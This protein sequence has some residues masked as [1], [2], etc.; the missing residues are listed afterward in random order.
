MLVLD[1]GQVASAINV[2]PDISFG[3][4]LEGNCTQSLRFALD[5]AVLDSAWFVTL[6][7][8]ESWLFFGGGLS[9]S[10]EQCDQ[11]GCFIHLSS[12]CIIN[13]IIFN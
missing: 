9:G 7:E 10:E 12:R 4:V 6:G 2:I 11:N 13:N 3:D 5:L 1:V 8:S